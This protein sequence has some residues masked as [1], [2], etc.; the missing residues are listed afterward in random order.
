MRR[1]LVVAPQGLGDSLEATPFLQAL[2]AADPDAT[3]HVAVTRPAA[4]ELFTG[5][6]QLVD[7]VLYLPY[8]ERGPMAFAASLVAHKVRSPRYDAAFLMYPAARAEYHALMR[9]FPARRRF[10]HRYWPSWRRALQWLK[11]DLV[12]VRRTHN[13]LRNLDL[14]AAA[15]IP[16]EIPT[17][18]AVPESWIAPIE[19]RRPDRIA[20]HVGTIAHDGLESRR[21]P[22]EYFARVAKW[23]LSRGY[24][25]TAISGPA[26]RH[27]TRRLQEMLPQIH[28]FEGALPDT[29]RFLSTARL[30]I[31]NDSGIGHL[32]AAVGTHEV[33][34]F[35]PTPIEHAPYGPNV[36]ALRPS[37]CPP[38][39]DVRLLN[40]TCAMHVDYECLKRDLSP[41]Y[42]VNCISGILERCSS[43]ITGEIA[44]SATS[45]VDSASA[46]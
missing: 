31:T 10:A 12:D 44:K 28:L 13:V 6:P 25:V 41:G 29:A 8:W 23:L 37:P 1:Y 32:A 4:R 7:R 20:M 2:R 18:Y 30:S 19:N 5:L 22:L 36:T 14:L 9:A 26:E 42:V 11:T 24:E 17:A 21:W 40:T 38:C 3:I 45:A 33:A 15:G 35:G 27:E 39:F 16:H 46:T 43:T 34:L